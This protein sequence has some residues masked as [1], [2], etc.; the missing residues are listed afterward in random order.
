MILQGEYGYVDGIE[1]LYCSSVKDFMRPALLKGGTSFIGA[2]CR[3]ILRHYLDTQSYEN[4]ME[5]ADAFPEHVIEFTT[6]YENIGCQARNTIIWE[7]RR[8]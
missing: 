4:M 7:I 5:L 6:A 2:S 3:P 1:H 8:Y